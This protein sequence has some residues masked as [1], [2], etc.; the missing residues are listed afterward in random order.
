MARRTCRAGDNGVVDGEHE[1]C[2]CGACRGTDVVHGGTTYMHTMVIKRAEQMFGTGAEV[3][4]GSREVL[5][6]C[7][8][9]NGL[10]SKQ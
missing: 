3:R 4:R 1:G 5:L 7:W 9:R 10:E 6:G 8:V 2:D